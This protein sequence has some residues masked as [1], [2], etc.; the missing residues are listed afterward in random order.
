MVSSY[1]AVPFRALAL[2][3]EQKLWTLL[4]S[5]DLTAVKAASPTLVI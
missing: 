3:R 1:T 2:L 5:A 4:D